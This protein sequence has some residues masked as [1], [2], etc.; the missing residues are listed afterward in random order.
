MEMVVTL[1]VVG[2]M[3]LL[4]ETVLPGGIAGILGM[5]SLLAGVVAAYYEFGARA[6]NAVL[7]GVSIA[8]IAG[9]ATWVKIFPTSRFGRTFI[10]QNAV[11]ELKVE[12]PELLH[13]TGVAFTQ[14]RPSGTA[15]IN[16]QR[17]DV[18]T[19]GAL[20]EKDTPIKVVAL[21]GLRVVVRTLPQSAPANT[22]T[23]QIKST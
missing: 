1:L 23:S 8:L 12:K 9:L 5:L 20:I 14:L 22:A 19:E 15:L 16:G 11:G 7:L 2:T 4:A 21:E 17:V 18:V 10:S 13:Q 3:L 6:G